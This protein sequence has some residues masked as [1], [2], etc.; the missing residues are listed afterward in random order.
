M[1]YGPAH[2]SYRNQ[3]WCRGCVA[4]ATAVGVGILGHCSWHHGQHFPSAG[5]TS[6][7]T[8]AEFLRILIDHPHYSLQGRAALRVCT[9]TSERSSASACACRLKHEAPESCHPDVPGLQR[10][11]PPW[12]V[13][14]GTV[15][16]SPRCAGPPRHPSGGR[17]GHAQAAT[18][19]DGAAAPPEGGCA[20]RAVLRYGGRRPCHAGG[21]SPR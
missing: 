11:R 10:E 5:A 3:T 14:S 17:A 7:T 13:S 12:I 9:L 19:H 15:T 2:I 8:L 6:V 20:V 1:S 21:Y 18:A 4:L 16:G